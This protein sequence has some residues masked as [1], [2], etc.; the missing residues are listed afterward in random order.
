V[1]TRKTT[2]T[3]PKK[4]R[5]ETT[6][7][8]Y[9]EWEAAVKKEQQL[10]IKFK[11]RYHC[12]GKFGEEEV[13]LFFKFWIA[14]RDVKRLAD[15]VRDYPDFAPYEDIYKA[16][17]IGGLL[18]QTRNNY[19]RWRWPAKSLTFLGQYLHD[20]KPD[21]RAA[22]WALDRLSQEE[23]FT[24]G[25][26]HRAIVEYGTGSLCAKL[27]DYKKNG[28]HDEDY[29]KIIKRFMEKD[30]AHYY[31]DHPLENLVKAKNL[32]D[33]VLTRIVTMLLEAGQFSW[34][35]RV[36]KRSGREQL[37]LVPL[38]QAALKV[39]DL[40]DLRR[41]FKDFPQVD[42]SKFRDVV[43]KL[44]VPDPDEIVDAYLNG[45]HTA[46]DRQAM[47]MALYGPMMLCGPPPWVR[48]R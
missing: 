9:H 14:R 30:P 24:P 7:T 45:L 19:P 26:F 13:G 48:S 41:F 34:A 23:D 47:M 15:A 33:W 16:G 4:T 1:A 32:P 11:D 38:E 10:A 29:K 31:N 28:L 22:A 17:L 35:C 8:L 12:R 2:K 36:A 20:Q 27:I 6:V 44:L 40:H 3:T 42:K 39:N 5:T 25:K 46:Y 21:P 18:C 43:R 37:V